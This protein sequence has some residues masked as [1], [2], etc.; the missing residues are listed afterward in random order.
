M[1]LIAC[2]SSTS[3]SSSGLPATGQSVPTTAQRP[4]TAPPTPPTPTSKD[5][6]LLEVRALVEDILATAGGRLQ[7]VECPPV[8]P[9]EIITVRTA[10]AVGTTKP[11]LTTCEA[12]L[13][14]DV[15]GSPRAKGYAVRL[16]NE[17]G[18]P[19]RIG[20]SSWGGV[21]LVLSGETVEMPL[22]PGVRAGFVM[23]LPYEIDSDGIAYAAAQKLADEYIPNRPVLHS[24]IGLFDCATHLS[25]ACVI[26]NLPALLPKTI[27]IRDVEV[28]A[29]AIAEAVAAAVSWAP[30]V[31][32]WNGLAAGHASG[33]ITI[34]YHGTG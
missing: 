9:F 30:L 5:T 23:N 32:K 13:L 8:P 25:A 24:F 33:T 28:P 11:A 18:V 21:S 12:P 19:V 3:S 29:R 7:P 6:A 31:Q 14:V 10:A 27:V 2:T 20:V 4:S 22:P 16:R 34:T 26:Q 17:S 15:P 1:S